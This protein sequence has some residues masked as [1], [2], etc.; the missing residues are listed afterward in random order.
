MNRV[1]KNSSCSFLNVASLRGIDCE[2][3]KKTIQYMIVN[4]HYGRSV[5][6]LRLVLMAKDKLTLGNAVENSW[7]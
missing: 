1:E 4:K 6:G 2:P 3:Y 5:A 7:K